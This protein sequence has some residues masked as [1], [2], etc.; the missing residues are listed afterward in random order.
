MNSVLLFVEAS[1][2]LLNLTSCLVSNVHSLARPCAWHGAVPLWAGFVSWSCWNT[3]FAIAVVRL[4][5]SASC[6]GLTLDEICLLGVLP[7]ARRF[8]QA[9]SADACSAWRFLIITFSSCCCP[10]PKIIGGS[11]PP[12]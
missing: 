3:L 1:A 7:L 11:N 2:Q 8:N 5:R 4:P 6:Q 10:S 12:A 9:L